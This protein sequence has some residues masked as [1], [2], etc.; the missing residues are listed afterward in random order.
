MPR[1]AETRLLV[2]GCNVVKH[3]DDLDDDHNDDHDDDHNDDYDND[4]DNMD[5]NYKPGKE[6]RS[7]PAKSEPRTSE[8]HCSLDLITI[9]LTILQQHHLKSQ[10]HSIISIK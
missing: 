6:G 8:V 5:D 9:H 3:N 4:D 2:I 1:N 10:K 7:C